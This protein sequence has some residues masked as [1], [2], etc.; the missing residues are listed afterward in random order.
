MADPKYCF[1]FKENWGKCMHFD[2]ARFDEPLEDCV[3]VMAMGRC[4]LRRRTN[5]VRIR[6]KE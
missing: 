1:Y 4:P 3:D 5:R 2:M 6:L